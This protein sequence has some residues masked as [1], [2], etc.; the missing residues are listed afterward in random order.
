MLS[1]IKLSVVMLN[2]AAPSKH[3]RYFHL[4]FA[5]KTASVNGTLEKTIACTDVI[6]IFIKLLKLR[7]KKTFIIFFFKKRGKKHEN[8]LKPKNLLKRTFFIFIHL[9]FSITY[10][11]CS[12]QYLVIMQAYISMV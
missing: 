10:I 3:L 5:T 7:R 2:V 1:V 11:K 9:Q 8:R 4:D 12:L 6:D